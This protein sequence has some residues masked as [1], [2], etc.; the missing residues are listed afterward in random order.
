MSVEIKP[1]F[2]VPFI[3]SQYHNHTILNDKLTEL[4][5]KK[6]SLGEKHSNNHELVVRNDK[7]FESSFDLFEWHD[8]CIEELRD[9][10][11]KILYQAIGKINNYDI[12]TLQKMHIGNSAWYHITRK[13][14][15]FGIHNHANASWSGVYCVKEGEQ[16]EGCPESGQLNFISPLTQTLSFTDKSVLGMKGQYSRGNLPVT[17]K[18]GQ[19]IIFPSWLLHEVKPYLGEK[20][21]ITVAFNAWFKYTGKL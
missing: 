8:E 10:C 12:K 21:R 13:G 1:F 4:F 2:S 17:L 19:L 11:W 5:L 6:E 16:V 18:P 14:G 20:E 7:L 9:F 3:I 15:Y